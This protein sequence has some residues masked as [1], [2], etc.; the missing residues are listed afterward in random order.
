MFIKVQKNKAYFKRFQV[1]YRRRRAGKTDYHRRRILVKQDKTKYNSP[2]YR[3]VV[4]FTNVDVVCQ[5]VYS[6]IGGDHVL[7]S[8]YSH[9]LTRYGVKAGLTNYAAA[10]CTGL[11]VAR[12]LLNKLGLDKRYEGNTDVNGEDYYVEAVA[13]GPAPFF[14]LLDV[15]LRRTTTGAKIFGALKG[16]CDGGL[17]VPHGEGRFV[18]YDVESSTLNAETLRKYIFGGHVADYMRK[19]SDDNETAFK[20]QFSRYIAAGVNADKIEAL[21]KSAHAAIRA[22][23]KPAAKK[24]R[25]AGFKHT[26]PARPKKSTYAE[27]QARIKAKLAKK[28]RSTTK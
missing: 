10:Y 27:K 26:I 2:K 24:T 21:Y 6:K 15:G 18:G 25:P 17:E 13:D 12:R 28:A 20:K 3:L 1:Q 5:V 8:A 11:L 7:A 22:D 19:L 4:R 14:C 16:A 9:E 23:P